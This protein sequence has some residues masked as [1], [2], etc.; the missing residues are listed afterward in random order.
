MRIHDTMSL[1]ELAQHMGAAATVDDAESMRN[2]LVGFATTRPG[3]HDTGDV[4]EDDWLA[5]CDMATAAADVQ[6]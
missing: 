5:M 1:D 4:P 6:S 2:I 3:V